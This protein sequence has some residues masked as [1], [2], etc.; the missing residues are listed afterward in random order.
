MMVPSSCVLLL[1][2]IGGLLLLLLNVSNKR[3]PRA[4]GSFTI[5][6]DP[7]KWYSAV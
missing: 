2:V 4:R 3:A 6:Y 7:I 1:P 5:V